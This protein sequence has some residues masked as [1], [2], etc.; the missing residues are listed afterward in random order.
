LA[1]ALA[2]VSVL[3]GAVVIA[4]A[5]VGAL[6]VVPTHLIELAVTIEPVA[7]GL[8]VIQHDGAGAE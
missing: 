7:L 5:K 1:S 6:Y 4:S 3:F 8:V 2:G